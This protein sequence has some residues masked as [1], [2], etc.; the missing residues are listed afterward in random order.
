[1]CMCVCVYIHTHIRCYS[2]IGVTMKTLALLVFLFLSIYSSTSQQY[3]LIVAK[4]GS[5]NY[6]NINDA[7]RN[8]PSN[9]PV[10]FRILIKAG[11]YYE[12][13]TIPKEKTNIVLVGEG[14]K[15]TNIIGDHN[16]FEG[17]PITKSATVGKF[18]LLLFCMCVS[19]HIASTL[20]CGSLVGI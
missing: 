15:V 7:I 20:N 10:P 1:M 5:G 2:Y 19:F 4:D 11:N 17:L 13:V 8:A 16:Q 3:N 18:F 9:S 6:K 12:Y 14:M